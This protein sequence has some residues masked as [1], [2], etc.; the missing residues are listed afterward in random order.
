MSQYV[1]VDCE[2]A[3]ADSP[4][5]QCCKSKASFVLKVE[6]YTRPPLCDLACPFPKPRL[7]I[8]HQCGEDSLL[9]NL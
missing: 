3:L 4:L 7:A 8:I 2:Q 6:S 1:L 5:T 9:S